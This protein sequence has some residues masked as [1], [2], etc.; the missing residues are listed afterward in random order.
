MKKK[1][2]ICTLAA[3]L[4]VTGCGMNTTKETS[5]RDMREVY[6]ELAAETQETEQQSEEASEQTSSVNYS[7]VTS[8]GNELSDDEKADLMSSYEFAKSEGYVSNAQIR[9]YM[10]DDI[11]A[12]FANIAISN[13]SRIYNISAKEISEN[14]E[15]ISGKFND[16]ISSTCVYGTEEELFSDAWLKAVEESGADISASFSSGRDFVYADDTEIY[17][18]GVLTLKVNSAKDLSKLQPLLPTDVEIGKQY[19]FVYDVGFLTISGD[20]DSE[21]KAEEAAETEETENAEEVTDR[22]EKKQKS[23]SD[24]GKI[25]YILALAVY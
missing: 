14:R 17:V 12:S 2:L 13:I 16:I 18:R 10:G 5:A 8:N 1:S 6:D 4:F 24:N 11:V 20:E 21:T 23:A 9:E 19:N 7:I 25:D 22:L 15:S 3:L